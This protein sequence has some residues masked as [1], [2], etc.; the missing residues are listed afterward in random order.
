VSR[1][2]RSPTV[3]TFFAADGHALYV[4][5]TAWPQARFSRHGRQTWWR[6]VATARY[7]HFATREEALVRESELINS[8]K[9]L[10]NHAPGTSR[11]VVELVALRE[12]RGPRSPISALF[13]RNLRTAR[14]L[15]AITQEQLAE[16]VGV[17]PRNIGRWESGYNNPH[18]G[19]LVRLAD[20]LGHEIA[21]FYTDHDVESTGAAA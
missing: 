17:K 7:E 20:V 6:D 9:P 5:S 13:G 21:W 14:V 19:N 8:L 3:Y 12:Q 4:G 2:E 18:A 10:H 11:T 15:Q 1:D 16:R